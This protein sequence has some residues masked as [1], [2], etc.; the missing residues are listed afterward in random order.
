MSDR[1]LAE[2]AGRFPPT[3]SRF[4]RNVTSHL[5]LPQKELH[6]A[7]DSASYCA[8]GDASAKV[9]AGRFLGRRRWWLAPP[10]P[11]WCCLLVGALACAEPTVRLDDSDRDSGADAGTADGDRSD[12]AV[13]LVWV[14]GTSVLHLI[15][16][17][18]VDDVE[19]DLSSTRFTLEGLDGPLA[20]AMGTAQ[21]TFELGP[22]PSAARFVVVEHA[23]DGAV[24]RVYVT[25]R[26][27]LQLDE[28]TLGRAP[29]TRPPLET[30]LILE[31]TGLSPLHENDELH[32]DTS[33]QTGLI[34]F[35][36]P[37]PL[38][39]SAGR[40]RF[41][42][43]VDW[44][45]SGHAYVTQDRYPLSSVDGDCSGI[46]R[47]GELPPLDFVGGGE[48]IV[49]V[50]LGPPRPTLTVSA[51]ID[52]V[53]RGLDPPAEP[54]SVG[55]RLWMSAFA[56]NGAVSGGLRDLGRLARLGA[57][58]WP[59]TSPERVSLPLAD[60]YDSDWERVVAVGYTF[61]PLWLRDSPFDWWPV[62]WL[63][64][65]PLESSFELRPALGPMGMPEVD[66]Q[67]GPEVVA[68]TRSTPRISWA[69]P[70][71]GRV[72]LYE[73]ALAMESERSFR[74]AFFTP[75][76]F[77]DVPRGVLRVGVTYRV[78]VTAVQ[79]EGL[80]PSRPLWAQ[81]PRNMMSLPS[82]PFRVAP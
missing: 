51:R 37:D 29:L 23:N 16:E 53:L 24:G 19:K 76:P 45:A 10:G 5:R 6:E 54:L 80:R 61:T 69:P 3:T 46:V 78:F 55:P 28:A 66:G 40:V 36:E 52:A 7:L 26:P 72:D 67:S 4:R 77:F 8:V 35:A 79:Q 32:L 12:A 30:S 17:Q 2:G 22:V 62:G 58:R 27:T 75:D 9:I 74:L 47:A 59:D 15:H 60:P 64:E 43:V 42:R 63:W 49:P 1:A 18:G 68:L 31:L 41:D 25:D 70:S 11:L 13:D 56:G 73:L 48:T 81:R 34:S 65:M 82:P 39:G 57:C 71:F 20:E 44:S 33:V 50:M 21:G 14:R 38:V